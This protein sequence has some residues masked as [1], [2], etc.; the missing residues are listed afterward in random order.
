MSFSSIIGQQS[1]IQ[2]LRGGIL[3]NTV[4]HA[5]LFVGP[6]GVGKLT[7]ALTFAKALN[8]P[9]GDADS[10]DACDSC[11]KID[12]Q[13]H[14]NIRIMSLE[15]GKEKVSIEQVRALQ[16]EIGLRG[17][18]T[19]RRVF[20]IPQAEKL[21]V[22]AS[23]AVLKTLEEPPALVTIILISENPSELLPT[24]ISRCQTIRFAPSTK[25]VVKEAVS[26]HFSIS[27][28]EANFL[29]AYS[30]GRVGIAFRMAQNPDV[31]EHRTEVIRLLEEYAH[32]ESISALRL[33]EGIKNL[34]PA[35]TL[36]EETE[37]EEKPASGSKKKPTVNRLQIA[38]SL[39]VALSW[40]RDLLAIK[41]NCEDDVL[42]NAD[43][44]KSLHE[45]ADRFTLE[46]LRSAVKVV[47]EAKKQITRN[48][49]PQLALEVMALS[50]RE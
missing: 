48:A 37:E 13:E 22:Q 31:L 19:G 46:E 42:L 3:R 30:N 43:R 15:G 4:A 26:S 11:R 39:D 50:I 12:E 44:V 9:N 20:I 40:F 23:N 49:N 10:C 7:T 36:D 6:D 16:H 2:I 1:A 24:V 47:A 32:G 41:E 45:N 33:A 14:P 28:E 38:A 8:C 25:E 17:T 27:K 35:F 34:T 21:T 5:Y 18:G 29:A